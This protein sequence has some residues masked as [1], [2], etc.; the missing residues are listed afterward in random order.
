M[1]DRLFGINCKGKILQADSY[2]CLAF[3]D[4]E[5]LELSET[6]I[7]SEYSVK[8]RTSQPHMLVK[9]RIL[10]YT[11]SSAEYVGTLRKPTFTK[12]SVKFTINLESIPAA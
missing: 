5:R 7:F 9:Y 11:Y 2:F 4:L 12:H 8:Y 10:S 6:N 3:A 1:A